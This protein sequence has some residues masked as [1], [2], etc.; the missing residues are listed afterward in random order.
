MFT[1]RAMCGVTSAKVIALCSTW[2]LQIISNCNGQLWIKL[3]D[4]WVL[5]LMLMKGPKIPGIELNTLH[6]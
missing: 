3:D 4:Q 2:S 6:L 1:A 5:M